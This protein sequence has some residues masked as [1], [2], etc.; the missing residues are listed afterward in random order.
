VGQT[1]FGNMPFFIPNLFNPSWALEGL[2]VQVESAS[3]GAQAHGDGSKRNGIASTRQ[4]NESPQHRT[5][6]AFGNVR[7]DCLD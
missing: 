6:S 3:S 4:T 7:S 5:Q 1:I 2:A